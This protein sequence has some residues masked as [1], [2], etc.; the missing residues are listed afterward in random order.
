[1]KLSIKVKPGSKREAVEQAGPG[2]LKVWLKEAPVDGKAN[3]ALLRVLAAHFGVPKA[4]VRIVH[5]ASGRDKLV[6]IAGL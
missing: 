5:G 1:M 3:A 4:R 2:S 6:E